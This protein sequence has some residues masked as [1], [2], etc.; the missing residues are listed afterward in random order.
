MNTKESEYSVSGL[1]R[2]VRLKLIEMS[3][4]S[5]L[6]G[7]SGVF[8][9]EIQRDVDRLLLLEKIPGPALAEKD[10]INLN[11]C[12]RVMSQNPSIAQIVA[13][14]FEISVRNIAIRGVGNA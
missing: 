6:I 7:S 10:W 2:T 5:R 3:E 14:G 11:T 13:T 1:T 9:Q 4:M 12:A 8:S